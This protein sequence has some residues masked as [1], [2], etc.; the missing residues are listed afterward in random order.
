MA[1]SCSLL[2]EDTF[3]CSVCLDVFTKPV[4]TPCGHNFCRR[5]IR[6]YWD[7]TVVWRCPLCKRSFPTKPDLQVNT[8][9]S[10]LAAEFKRSNQ[11]K[12]SASRTDVPA[13]ADVP[14]DVC[15][16]VKDKAVKSCLMCLT[17]FCKTH[18][19]PHERIAGLHGHRLIN[20]VKDLDQKMCRMHHKLTELYCR[21]DQ[22]CI[23]VLC[24]KDDHKLHNVVTIEE[25]YESAV[26]EKSNAMVNIQKIIQS[27]SDK[28]AEIEK[29]LDAGKNEAEKEKE[30]T[31]QV[32]TNFMRFVER[33]QNELV[34]VIEGRYSASKEKGEGFL[35]ELRTEVAELESRSSHLEQL[36]DDH[37]HFLQN[38]QALSCLSE[39]DWTDAVVDSDLCLSPVREAV[40]ALHE[41]VDYIMEKVPELSWRRM[42]EHAVDLTFDP[43]TTQGT[44]VI[45]EDGKQV[46]CLDVVNNPVD[47]YC[48]VLTKEG[49]TSGKF[50]YEVKVTGRDEWRVGVAIESSGRKN[51]T[52]VLAKNGF[53]M[54][55]TRNGMCVASTTPVAKVSKG[56]NL[57]KVGI[58]VE[59]DKERVSF[60]DVDSK[61][62]IFS[63]NMCSFRMFT[64]GL[65][66]S[67]HLKPSRG[68]I[69]VIITPV[70][71]E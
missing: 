44:L 14:C 34:E 9:L 8:V 59:I 64:E 69:P 25:Q 12:A 21:T 32:F 29:A 63:F 50:Y 42:R 67:F 52:K 20:P 46:T 60:Y 58:F 13:S 16:Q 68:N 27:R 41:R 57:G 70:P 65:Y 47:K 39:K 54:I 3:L 23:C 38:L 28:I 53:W 48:S 31:M 56:G 30:A 43:D 55:G 18:L 36:S 71:Q 35:Q 11:A 19:E 4:S 40:T 62:H 6:T 5:C 51:N 37:H 45:S 1:M 24:L 7:S 26:E 2:S 66:P 17:S 10:E 15:S 49:F 61:S 22:S 33:R